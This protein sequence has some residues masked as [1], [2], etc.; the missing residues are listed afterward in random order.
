M[1]TKFF[2]IILIVALVLSQTGFA[3]ADTETTEEPQVENATEEIVEETV[4]EEPAEP[5]EPEAV[6]EQVTEEPAAPSEEP[7]ASE[8][9]EEPAAPVI[10]ET[11]KAEEPKTEEA[12]SEPVQEEAQPV[13]QETPAAPSEAKTAPQEKAD[14]SAKKSNA[15]ASSKTSAKNPQPKTTMADIDFDNSTTLCDGTYL[16]DEI[17]FTWEGGTGRA[18]LDIDKVVVKNGKALGYFTASSAN[19]THVY[20]AHTSSTDEDPSIYDPK[21]GNKAEGVY[22]IDQDKK[23]VIPVKINEKTDLAMRTKAMGPPHWINYDYTINIE[24]PE[25]FVFDNSTSIADGLYT[26]DSSFHIYP[27]HIH[28]CKIL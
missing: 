12:V 1:K 2:A 21:T 3:F 17:T 28:R 7:A 27:I 6:E 9:A 5:E 15:K 14:S 16:P 18:R 13:V 4:T 8:V 22:D 23:V 20:L 25:P 10:E 24:E 19:A 26:A 11:P